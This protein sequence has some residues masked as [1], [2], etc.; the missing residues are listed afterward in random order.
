MKKPIAIAALLLPALGLGQPPGTPMSEFGP[1]QVSLASFFDHSGQDL[2]VEGYPSLLN[3]TGFGLEY[4]PWTY[5]Q[6][7][8]FGGVSEFDVALPESRVGEPDAAAYNTDYRFT[9]GGTL[10]LATPRFASGT[11][12]FVAYGSAA[13]LDSEDE[14]GNSKKGKLYQAGA[15]VQYMFRDR[16][17]FVLG[18]EFRALDGEQVSSLGA[19]APFG[20]TAPSG[21][22]DKMRGLVGVEYFFKG[23]NRPFVSIA[24]RPTGSIG[25]HDELGL[26]N[27]SISI[28]LGAMATLAK[29]GETYEEDES[30]LIDE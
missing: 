23:R 13:Y 12:R 26:R 28:S 3:T 8:I 1:S 19:Y 17:N 22:V 9:G 5:V 25:W 21:I 18:G 29:S 6:L 30:G 20:I 2:F 16:L 27:A 11:T 7:G 24:F 4:A 15:T 10:K 14:L